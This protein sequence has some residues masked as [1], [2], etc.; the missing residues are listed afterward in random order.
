MPIET[1]SVETTARVTTALHLQ[2]SIQSIGDIHT[3]NIPAQL[4]VRETELAQAGDL[5]GMHEGD[6][7]VI[8]GVGAERKQDFDCGLTVAHL[9]GDRKGAGD[10]EFSTV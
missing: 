5:E 4:D 6:V 3:E 8:T 1:Y 2:S 10:G 9:Q 7:I